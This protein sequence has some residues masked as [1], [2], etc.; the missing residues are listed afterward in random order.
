M[1]VLERLI[2]TVPG[3]G[4]VKDR[5][6]VWWTQVLFTQLLVPSP[7]G[8]RGQILNRRQREISTVTSLIRKFDLLCSL[9]SLLSSLSVF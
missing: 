7:V 9:V 5:E 2:T 4:R 6:S 1:V 8:S 3:Y